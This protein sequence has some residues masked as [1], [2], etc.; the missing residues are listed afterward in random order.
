[1]L[2]NDKNPAEVLKPQFVE[3]YKKLH[4]D[5]WRRLIHIH[6]NIIILERIEPFPFHHFYAAQENVFW[7]MVYWNFL[8]TS[9]ILIYALVCDEGK[10]AHKPHKPPH[11]LTKFKNDIL[12]KWLKD[13]EKPAY[14]ALLKTVKFAREIE[15]IRRK[16]VA[17]RN[18][19]VAHR[20]L[21][22]SHPAQVQSADRV[23]VP[24]L[25][26]LYDATEKMFFAC[27]FGAE[28]KTTFIP[29][30]VLRHGTPAPKDID[31]ILDL[32]VKDSPWL[33]S[34]ER[35]GAFWKDVRQYKSEEYLKELNTW[36][37]KFGLPPA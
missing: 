19:V 17:M 8:Y 34:P 22:D 30:F 27:C 23:T 28:Y 31:Q 25:R 9:I 13:S 5:I 21:D 4:A 29:Y 37:Q 7:T 32:I 33:N 26:S 10:H 18:K 2:I 12:R 14:Q 6:T 36:R 1:M 24:E 3:A 20:L 11:T 16:V 35:R 15:K